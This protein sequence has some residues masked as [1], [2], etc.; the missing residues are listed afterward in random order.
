MAAASGEFLF[1]REKWRFN[2]HKNDNEGH[3]GGCQFTHVQH[4]S[5]EIKKEIIDQCQLARR[6]DDTEVHDNSFNLIKTRYK[7]R[8][9]S[10]E[11]VCSMMLSD[12]G[13]QGSLTF[14]ISELSGLIAAWGSEVPTKSWLIFRNPVE[15]EV[16]SC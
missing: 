3:A 7:Y 1:A 6:C 12:H 5:G 10:N 13:K 4:E 9:N 16:A 15:N 8:S 2:K 14:Q 11:A